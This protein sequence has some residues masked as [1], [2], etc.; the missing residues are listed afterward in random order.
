MRLATAAVACV[1]L[2]VGLGYWVLGAVPAS[3]GFV[4][5][6]DHSR[7]LPQGDFYVGN[8]TE[9]AHLNPFTSSDS[10]ALSYELRFTHD[11]L[12]RMDPT[13]G[14][15]QPAAA[16]IVEE[17]ADGLACTFELREGLQFS[18]GSPVT[19]ADVRFTF[20]V[21]RDRAVPVGTI[22]DSVARVERFADLGGRRFRLELR[23]YHF[24]GLRGMAIGYRIV[25]R[26]F[27]L[28]RVARK[29]RTLGL[30]VP[31]GPG[32]PGFAD[33]LARVRLPGPGTGPYQI[34]RDAS[35]RPVWNRGRDLVLTQNPRSW[36]RAVYPRSWNLAGIKLRFLADP[37]T[38]FAELR[39][40]AL[41]WHLPANPDMLLA[42]NPELAAHFRVLR[43]DSSKLGQYFVLWNHTDGR[44]TADRR[45]R[46]ALTMLFDR[47]RIVREVFGGSATV[48]RSWFK[49]GS[50]QYPVGL[51]EIGYDPQAAAR[52]L[53]EAGFGT[54]RPLRLEILA[55]PD[56]RYRR[57]LELARPSFAQA[58]VVLE[59]RILEWVALS[60]QRAEGRFDGVMM[61]WRH[62]G[63]GVDPH[64]FFHSNPAC[65][66]GGHNHM[67][68]RN[69]EVDRLLEAARS[70]RDAERR[71]ALY[72]QFNQLVH[73]DQPITLLVHPL[74][75]LLLHRRL[76][77][78]EPGATGVF[79]QHWWVAPAERLHELGRRR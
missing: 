58:G 20:D 57:V 49:R 35:G 1:L 28:R 60:A 65:K 55:P 47:E 3:G 37:Q 41:D 54:G 67:C 42:E 38:A 71:T 18:D 23:D 59:A 74:N 9:P 27:Y 29:A 40:Q 13:T 56:P 79:P 51:A 10:V 24:T 77:D 15:L 7:E 44:P 16:R 63:L 12:M 33:L 68:Y 62:S 66:S 31:A 26:A 78:A 2:F 30:P 52:L 48:A 34:A 50:P 70:E 69:A 11:C 53:A 19:V 25:Q 8:Y 39:K 61:Y 22:H 75:T 4:V 72:Q 32:R 17:S 6:L 46:R 76:Q 73:A 21:V 43:Y 36:H 5:P 64:E 14:E 45:V